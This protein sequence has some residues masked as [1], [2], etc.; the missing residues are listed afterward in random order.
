MSLVPTL[1]VLLV[2][3]LCS[4]ALYGLTTL[5]TYLYFNSSWITDT[6]KLKSF[7]FFIW[8]LETVHT[9]LICAYIFRALVL[10]QCNPSSQLLTRVSDDVT[11]L[12]TQT[13]IIFSIH[14]FYIR[15]LFILSER[16][17]RRF[18]LLIIGGI[19]LLASCHFDMDRGDNATRFKY[20]K[21]SEFHRIMDYYA[22]SLAVAAACDVTIAVFIW[23]ILKSRQSSMKK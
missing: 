23:L 1:G 8:L 15:R 20:P 21:F 9:F 17:N 22:A 5:Q 12:I 3:D 4:V 19:T 13:V 6:W 14:L 16:M 2:G 11:T 10:E 7:V 18:H